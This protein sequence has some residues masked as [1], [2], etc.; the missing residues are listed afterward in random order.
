MSYISEGIAR[1]DH[2]G[3]CRAVV[4]ALANDSQ[5]IEKTVDCGELHF[6][7]LRG[8]DLATERLAP[9]EIPGVPAKMLARD[10]RS[11]RLAVEG[12]VIAE[13]RD[14]CRVRLGDR[15]R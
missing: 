7:R 3:A 8:V 13:V 6:C 5:C 2:V 15:R 12:V 1:I 10:P 14:D 9:R 4:E 11:R